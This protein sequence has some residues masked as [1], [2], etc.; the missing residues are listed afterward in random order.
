MF[1]EIFCAPSSHYRGRE[2]FQF[3]VEVDQIIYAIICILIN[4]VL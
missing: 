3:I 1:I 2:V 4:T